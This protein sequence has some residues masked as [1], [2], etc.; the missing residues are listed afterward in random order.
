MA[1]W[2]AAC[3]TPGPPPPTT[4]PAT[5][6]ATVVNPARVDRSRSA[7][8]EGYEVRAYTGLPAPGALWGLRD[9]ADSDPP[10]CAALA[11][12]TAD[13]ATAKGWSASGAGGIAYA[14]VAAAPGG[15]APPADC[16]QWTLSSGPT[17]ARV[18]EV[19][20][21]AVDAARTVG[22]RTDATTVVEGGTETRS[23][24]DTFIA[25]LG[26]YICVVALVTDPGSP[27]P[28]LEPGFASHLLTETVSAL[29]G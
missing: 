5:P 17:T 6:T 16:A 23:H 4:N 26:D 29:R 27:H 7:L 9:P 28:A 22:M 20:A 24:A 21:P 8:P 11:L 14:V 13:A 10:Q 12:P 19:P 15:P 3:G 1:G 25:Y 18:R 2:C